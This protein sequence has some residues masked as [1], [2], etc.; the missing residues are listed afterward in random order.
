MTVDSESVPFHHAVR[1]WAW[2]DRAL[3]G[4]RA[5]PACTPASLRGGCARGRQRPP[6]GRRLA[7]QGR[8]KD[9]QGEGVLNVE[10]VD[11]E[12]R[13]HLRA[14][15]C[16]RSST[17]A[18]TKYRRNPIRPPPRSLASMASAAACW[19]QSRSDITRTAGS[20]RHEWATVDSACSCVFSVGSDHV[21]LGMQQLALPAALVEIEHRP[22][23]SRKSGSRPIPCS[24]RLGPQADRA[25][26][27][28]PP[29][30]LCRHTWH[31]T[32][33]ATASCANSAANSTRQRSTCFLAGKLARH[34]RTSAISAGKTP[35]ADPAEASH[36]SRPT[37]RL[38]L[39]RHFIAVLSCSPT[40]ERSPCRSGPPR[41]NSTIFA[42][43]TSRC[44][45]VYCPAR[46]RSARSS[47]A[48]ADRYLGTMN[49]RYGNFSRSST[50]AGQQ[51]PPPGH[52]VDPQPRIARRHRRFQAAGRR[53]R[54]ICSRSAK[55]SRPWCSGAARF[56][57]ASTPAGISQPN[58]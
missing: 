54:F 55:T 11:F 2:A 58:S 32:P 24:V 42:R 30:R 12:P 44:G 18:G 36:S 21:S 31:T 29:H 51:P 37:R 26:A 38:D 10:I 43:I 33:R 57:E 4:D 19:P 8:D 28:P 50:P 15:R 3:R 5:R 16:R 7:M 53:D 20:G 1:R 56:R 41:P 22:A 23:F 17:L 14:P 6:A 49:R 48:Q 47:L 35:A 46:R 25:L 39:R 45:R 13:A 34:A 40:A 9:E 52:N 27:Q